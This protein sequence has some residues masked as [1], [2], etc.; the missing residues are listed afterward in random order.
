ML[1]V[2]GGIELRLALRHPEQALLTL[3][4]PVLILVGI[5][6]LPV[7]SLPT[8]RVAHVLPSVLAIAVVSTAFTSQAIVL[9][10][11]RR[12]GVVHRLAATAMPRWLLCAGR[13]AASLGVLAVQ[14]MVLCGV[15]MTLGWRPSWL[16]G[17]SLVLVLL[18]GWASFGAWGVLVGGSLR[19][20]VTLAVANVVWFV[21]LIAGGVG[22]PPEDLP[23][24]L[25]I[26]DA[27]LPSGALAHALSDLIVRHRPPPMVAVLVLAGWAALGAAGSVRTFRL[28]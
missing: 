28:R 2:Q 14:I 5:T 21:L 18:L 25:A 23:R 12:Y 10:F 13:G 17:V 7:I 1:W 16:A 11:D 4:V 27:W 15:A 22:V 6:V 3:F 8:P 9:G 26:A 19:A 20:E 24:P